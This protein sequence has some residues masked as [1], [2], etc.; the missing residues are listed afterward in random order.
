VASH[1]VRAVLAAPVRVEGRPVGVLT[2]VA[3][4]SRL[5]SEG[6]AH[7]IN[8][9]AAMLGRLLVIAADAVK[10]R[11]LAGQLRTALDT[12]IVIEQAKGVLMERKMLSP[13]QAFQ[14]LRRMA[15]S[16]SRKLVDV[17]ADI[18]ANPGA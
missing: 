12:R 16:S 18:I 17:A 11:R 5:W 9:Y 14:V 4:S 7:A 1:D 13:S 15:R 6:E 3:A 2:V 8:A 10:Q